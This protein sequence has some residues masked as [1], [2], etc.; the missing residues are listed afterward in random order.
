MVDTP[1][2]LPQL[3]QSL[4][5]LHQPGVEY[6]GM[7]DV[8]CGRGGGTNNH[9]GNIRFRQ[10][11]NEHKLRYLAAPKIDKPKVAMEV[12]QMWR[13]LDPPGRF[14]AKT[15][16]EKFWNEVGD[17]K[18][19]EKASQC[20]RERTAVVMPFVKALQERERKNKELKNRN[21]TLKEAAKANKSKVKTK[22]TFKPPETLSHDDACSS[23]P[24]TVDESFRATK[25]GR[26]RQRGSNQIG[27]NVAQTIPTAAALME[28]LFDDGEND[29]EKDDV[30]SYAAQ[31]K[32]LQ[33]QYSNQNGG[34]EISMMNEIA[35]ESQDR[36]TSVPLVHPLLNWGGI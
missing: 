2:L 17:K 25:G 32:Q 29:N 28:N 21:K 5:L 20:L 23:I 33:F 15:A 13:R 4:C 30:K 26:K 14:L 10:L 7:N 18:A 35:G 16:G 9:V 3:Q 1:A 12:V 24:A 34:N 36:G 6:P 11:I 31:I 22:T 27:H 19:R 8:M